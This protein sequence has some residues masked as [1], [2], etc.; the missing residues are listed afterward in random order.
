MKAARGLEICPRMRYSSGWQERV[1]SL[2]PSLE[3]NCW[4][5]A[6]CNCPT[7]FPRSRFNYSP[8]LKEV[9]DEKTSDYALNGACR[10]WARG[11]NHPNYA[12]RRRSI[13]GGTAFRYS[14]GVQTIIHRQS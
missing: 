5:W 9:D 6:N 13:R 1:I 2:S 10:V 14:C 12:I 8:K 11:S 4:W 7:R 3:E